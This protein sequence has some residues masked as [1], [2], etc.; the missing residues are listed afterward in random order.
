VTPIIP[1]ARPI[2]LA[3][4]PSSNFGY[5]GLDVTLHALNTQSQTVA[6]DGGTP[7]EF[8]HGDV[9]R[10]GENAT[11]GDV[12]SVTLTGTDG[13][14][15]DTRTFEF[16]RTE[17]DVR[18]RVEFTHPTWAQ[19]RIWA[20]NADGN[21]SGGEWGSAPLMTRETVNGQQVWVHY[22]PAGTTMP[23]GVVFHNGAGQQTADFTITGSARITHAGVIT[24]I[25]PPF[26][27]AR[28]WVE[29]EFEFQGEDGVEITLRAEYMRTRFHQVQGQPFASAFESG[30]TM[31]L[32]RGLA[33]GQSTYVRLTGTGLDG[34]QIAE[35]FRV[36]RLAD[37]VETPECIPVEGPLRVEFTHPT[38]N[39]VSIWA[40]H[41][42]GADSVFGPGVDWWTAPSME[43]EEIDG[44]YVWVF[45]FDEDVVGPLNVIFHNGLG[46]SQVGA[47][48]VEES[49][50]VIHDG[51]DGEVVVLPP[52]CMDD[53]G[54]GGDLPGDGG[55]LPGDGADVPGDGDDTDTGQPE[56]EV[57]VEITFVAT[58]GQVVTSRLYEV[59]RANGQA[60]DGDLVARLPGPHNQAI[61][62]RDE[63]GTWRQVNSWNGNN[64]DRKA[65]VMGLQSAY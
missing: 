24:P 6:V 61:V 23:L 41:T 60:R 47:F 59:I 38:W 5:G 44:E 35:E 42:G 40:W 49:S 4:A 13:T 1:P 65:P 50:R 62:V 27:E 18:V 14:H 56:V 58:N 16:I 51:R 54:E 3:T 30:H 31:V 7:V 55:E 11:A 39:N 34:T 46:T 45:E 17:P 8:A 37:D 12:V 33:V 52:V 10:I 25:A 64:A 28:L 48:V 9:V 57:H 63:D 2:V 32:G 19:T 53:D 29:G 15:T 36:T 22:F 20:W 21:L 26:G 43:R